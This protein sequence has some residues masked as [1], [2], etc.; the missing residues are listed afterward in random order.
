M[1]KN[2]LRVFRVLRGDFFRIIR[3]EKKVIALEKK[4][5]DRVFVVDFE[6]LVMDTERAMTDMAVFLDIDFTDLLIRPTCFGIEIKKDGMEY[7]GKVNDPDLKTISHFRYLL[8]RFLVV[9]SKAIPV[10]PLLYTKAFDFISSL[11]RCVA[12]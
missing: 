8:L 7:I 9:F 12:S 6:K 5:P 3:L 2:Y 4:Y 1:Y 11:K 10:I